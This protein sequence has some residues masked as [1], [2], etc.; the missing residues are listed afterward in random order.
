MNN[1]LFVISRRCGRLANRLVVFANFIALAEEQG[2]RLINVN[3]HT[4]ADCFN[5]TSKDVYCRYP[6][7]STPDLLNAIPPLTKLIKKT[8]IFYHMVRTA[9]VMNERYP[10]FGESVVT[11]RETEGEWVTWLEEAHIQQKIDAAKVV[12]VYGWGFRA[13]N[14]VKKHAEKIREYFVPVEEYTLSSRQSVEYLRREADIVIGVHI[15]QGDYHTLRGGQY[16]FQTLQYVMWMNELAEQFPTKKVSFLVCSDEQHDKS[17]FAGLSIGFGP[18][19]AVGDL[20]ALAQ[21]DMILGPMS[22]FSQWASFY[23]NKPLYHI[24]DS[25]TQI[26]LDKFSVSFL[27]EIP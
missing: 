11:L 15:R 10:V 12:F 5:T 24:M 27:A 22:T 7:S 3:F 17:T 8:R 13:P 20:Y 25:K 16:L 26:E 9:A 19:T 21:C 14:F 6:Q 4:Y 23:G 2:H 1:K 18:G